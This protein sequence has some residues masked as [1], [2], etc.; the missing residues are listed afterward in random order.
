MNS[1]M[2]KAKFDSFSSRFTIMTGSEETEVKCVEADL[3]PPEKVRHVVDCLQSAEDVSESPKPSFR[4]WTILDYS[5]AYTSGEI[6]PR[7]VSNIPQ[8]P[9]DYLVVQSQCSIVLVLNLCFL[10]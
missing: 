8:L 1:S 9:F 5:R 4:R 6:T 7:M 2:C 10:N 3:P